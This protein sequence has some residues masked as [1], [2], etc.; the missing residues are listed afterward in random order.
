MHLYC[1]RIFRLL[2]LNKGIDLTVVVPQRF[3][4]N[5]VGTGGMLSLEKPAERDGYRLLPVPLR[6]PHNYTRGYRFGDLSRVIKEVN[7]DIIHVWDEPRSTALLQVAFVHLWCRLKAKVLFYAFENIPFRFKPFFDP[8]WHLVVWPRVAGGTASN[9]EALE[10]L[11]ARGLL[12]DRASVRIFWGTALELFGVKDKKAVRTTHNL[13][14]PFIVG[15]VG[16]LLPQK[17]FDTLLDAVALL[18]CEVHCVI[19]GSGPIQDALAQ[20]ASRPDLTGRVHFLSQVPAEEMVEYMNCFDLLVIPSRTTATWKE[21][22]GKVIPE[23]MACGV[24]VI[25]SDSGA[26]PEVIGDAGLVFPEGDAKALGAAIGELYADPVKTGALAQR[27]LVR[28]REELSSEAFAARHVVFYQ[29]LLG[30]L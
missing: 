14:Y 5:H 15:G 29:R 13:A 20:R 12:A 8:L 4:P 21:Q 10:I 23:A 16:G 28:V 6:T 3:Y 27:G 24:P 22:F 11:E 7:P 19:I 9:S 1:Q 25:G 17:G 26:I 30:I 2:T 18:P